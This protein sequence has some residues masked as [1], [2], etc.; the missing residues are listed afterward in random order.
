MS[1]LSMHSVC[2]KL[3][4]YVKVNLHWNFTGL[5]FASCHLTITLGTQ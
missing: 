2:T 1:L 4:V 5:G 3:K